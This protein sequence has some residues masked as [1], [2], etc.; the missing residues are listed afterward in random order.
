MIQTADSLNSP[1][2][3]NF[4]MN[5]GGI[6]AID[7]NGNL[8]AVSQAVPDNGLLTFLTPDG[9]LLPPPAEVYCEVSGEKAWFHAIGC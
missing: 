7:S 9:T 5:D 8:V 6:T 1:L 2:A 4:T 3:Q